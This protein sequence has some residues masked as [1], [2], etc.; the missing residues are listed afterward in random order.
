MK[1]NES[2][3]NQQITEC[4]FM[5]FVIFCEISLIFSKIHNVLF[6]SVKV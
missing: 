4:Y 2:A 5:K 1:Y 3:H 6:I